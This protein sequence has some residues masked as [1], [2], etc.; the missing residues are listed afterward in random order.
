M[1]TYVEEQVAGS[2]TVSDLELRPVGLAIVG[3]GYWGPNLV[4]NALQSPATRL[5]AVCDVDPVRAEKLVS[6]LP[7]VEAVDDLWRLLDDPTVEGIA[8]FDRGGS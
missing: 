8:V 2:W 4:R 6:S 1:S 5:S 3:T 7:R